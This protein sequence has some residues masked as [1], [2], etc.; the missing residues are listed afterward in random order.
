MALLPRRQK[1]TR[2]IR[3]MRYI[4]SS[5]E[6]HLIPVFHGTHAAR[7]VRSLLKADLPKRLTDAASIRPQRFF[8]DVDFVG[9]QCLAYMR[10]VAANHPPLRVHIGGSQSKTHPA[11]TEAAHPPNWGCM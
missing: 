6:T 9:N 1:I 11:S 3:I 10:Q 8:Q 4:W 5:Q 2:Q 7:L